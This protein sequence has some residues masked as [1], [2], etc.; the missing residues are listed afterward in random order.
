MKLKRIFLLLLL[1]LAIIF[2]INVMGNQEKPQ[3]KGIHNLKI[4]PMGE[5]GYRYSGFIQL[6]NPSI[7]QLRLSAINLQFELNN[8]T[9]GSIQQPVNLNI[10]SK[11]TGNYPFE[12]RFEKTDIDLQNKTSLE[13]HFKGSFSNTSILSKVNV[14]IDTTETVTIK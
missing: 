11:E 3:L 4:E 7:F 6:Y 10:S 5:N 12:L 1:V 8:K 9:I 13:A 2:G 14:N